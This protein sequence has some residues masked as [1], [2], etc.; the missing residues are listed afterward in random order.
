MKDSSFCVAIGKCS[1]SAY[2]SMAEKSSRVGH[3]LDKAAKAVAAEAHMLWMRFGNLFKAIKTDSQLAH[4]EM[5][6]KDDFAKLGEEIFRH[7]EPEIEHLIPDEDFQAIVSRVREDQ[8]RI[9]SIEGEKSAQHR[10]MREMSV[11]K[12][13]TAQLDSSDPR[14]RRAALRVLERMGRTDAIP[15]I[16]RLL[17]DLDDEVRA[18]ARAVIQKLSHSEDTAPADPGIQRGTRP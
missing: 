17:H 7:K 15:H 6:R 14:M 18:R 4:W 2:R 8:D 3:Y 12:H 16:S 5:K 10:R 11:F 9:R 13:A 1:G